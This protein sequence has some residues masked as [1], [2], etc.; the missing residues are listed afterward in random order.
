MDL[1][2][3]LPIILGHEYLGQT[4]KKKHCWR[5]VSGKDCLLLEKVAFITALSNLMRLLQSGPINFR[6]ELIKPASEI[7]GSAIP[8]ISAPATNNLYAS[9]LERI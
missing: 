7:V 9:A 8:T 3:V 6:Q 2:W 1:F 5:R 4:L